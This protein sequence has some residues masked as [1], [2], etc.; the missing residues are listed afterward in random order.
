MPN[1]ASTTFNTHVC[2]IFRSNTG[3]VKEDKGGV[4]FT[5]GWLDEKKR[6]VEPRRLLSGPQLS[7]QWMLAPSIGPGPEQQ[8][9]VRLSPVG[10]RRDAAPSIR[11]QPCVLEKKL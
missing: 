2:D 9:P 5:K 6:A 11:S 3:Y 7:S 4:Y 1:A 10:R 8:E